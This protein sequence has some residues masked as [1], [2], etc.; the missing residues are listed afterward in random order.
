MR[1]LTPA[2]PEEAQKTALL[3]SRIA[4][5]SSKEDLMR[6]LDGA[7][8]MTDQQ[9]VPLLGSLMRN[10]DPDVQGRALSLLEGVNSP[11]VLPVAM[12]GLASNDEDVRL[13]ALDVITSVSSPETAPVLAGAFVD[14]DKDVR[15]AAFA[16]GMQQVGPTRDQLIANATTSAYPDL[17]LAALNVVRSESKKSTTPLILSA[18]SHSNPLVREFAHETLY[19]NFHNDLKTTAEATQWWN[20]HQALFDDNLALKD[21]STLDQILPQN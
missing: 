9:L 1:T 19:M 8:G 17:A 12:E 15:Q 18:L 21:L 11:D 5:A 16:A 13:V 7:A 6:A 2:T 4:A 10:P 14:P 20:K 3:A